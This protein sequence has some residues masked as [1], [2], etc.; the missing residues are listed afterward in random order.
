VYDLVVLGD[1][2]LEGEL[3]VRER[4]PEHGDHALEGLDALGVVEVV[5]DLG[6]DVSVDQAEV[7]LVPGQGEGGVTDPLVDLG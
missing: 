2:V 1:A 7:G 4:A 6:G 5:D 3:E